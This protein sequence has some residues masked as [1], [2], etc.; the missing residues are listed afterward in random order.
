M[1]DNRHANSKRITLF[2]AGSFLENA[3][4]GAQDFM[5]MSKK[6]IG[7]YF[8]GTLGSSV[9]NGL[10]FPEIDLLLPLL[11]DVPKDD[12]T[13]RE[14]VTT[15]YKNLATNIPFGVGRELEIGL[16]LDNDKP[17]TW[18]NEKDEPNLPIHLQDYIR[19]RHA[20]GHPWVAASKSEALGNMLKHFY[21]FDETAVNAENAE[22]G[23]ARDKAIT[24]YLSIK[25]D[26]EKIDAM[27]TLM[28]IDIRVYHG[29]DKDDLK[30]E[31]L[32]SLASKRYDE[33]N[34]IFEGK[35]FEERFTVQKMINTGVIRKVGAQLID[36]ET[37]KVLGHNMEEI[38]YYMKDVNNSDIV[39]IL[40]AKT[41]EAMKKKVTTSKPGV[42]RPIPS[43]S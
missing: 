29:V 18:R 3:Q 32:R 42:K 6:S 9:G 35:H 28:G 39:S 26:G 7:S 21:I 19:Y 5:A 12:R 37:G 38:I 24:T 40:K 14:A 1:A 2:L 23:K 22:A 36:N 17:T 43:R 10:S 13:F 8:A 11:I 25:A 33:F 16:T 4:T 30:L 15:F 31:E 34:E 27:L 20:K 41:Q